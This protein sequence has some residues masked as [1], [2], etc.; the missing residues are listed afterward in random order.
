MTAYALAAVVGILCGVGLG[1]LW[2]KRVRF[3]PTRRA[4]PPPSEVPRAI[5]RSKRHQD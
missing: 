1:D 5:G 3:A 2:R 4:L